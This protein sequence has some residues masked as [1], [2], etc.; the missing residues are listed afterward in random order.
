MTNMIKAGL[1]W[2][3]DQ[4]KEHCTENVLYVRGAT[5]L[6]VAAE[7]GRSELEIT[8]MT[9]G[10]T[11]VVHSDRDFIINAADIAAI[12][13]PVVGDVIEQ[14]IGAILYYYEVC[15]PAGGNPWTWVNPHETRMRIHTKL[16]DT[17]DA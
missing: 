2:L 17:D 10:E 6:L 1:T 14:T 11:R 9:T 3:A 12:V 8:D 16:V 7:I 13:P 15:A 5:E 4:K